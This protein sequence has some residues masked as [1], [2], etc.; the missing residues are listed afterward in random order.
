M[1]DTKPSN[2]PTGRVS[3]SAA[4]VAV[5]VAFAVVAVVFVT[6]TVS[7]G[8][9]AMA[10]SDEAFDRGQMLRSLD[11]A[12]T[13]ASRYVPYTAH[14]A[15]AHARLRAIALG[16]EAKG[17]EALAARAWDLSRGA[18][19][20]TWS[21]GKHPALDNADEQLARLL[22]RTNDPKKDRQLTERQLMV[23]LRGS[24]PSLLPSLSGAGLISLLAGVLGWALWGTPPALG[25]QRTWTRHVRVVGWVGLC[26]SGAAL[27][28]VA[29]LFSLGARLI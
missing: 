11:E 18:F 27:L 14:V 5:A 4:A 9:A 22:V 25:L 12:R 1:T 2:G 24:R 17:D 21:V 28:T 23:E 26:L 29:A 6:S 15:R 16:A 20:E 8:R 13:A 10:R 19:I 3:F 7:Q